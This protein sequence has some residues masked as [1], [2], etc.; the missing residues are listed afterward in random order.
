MSDK[1]QLREKL[2]IKRR[3]FQG[4]RREIAD[5]EILN[6]FLKAFSAYDSFFIYN[7]FGTE[8]D[9]HN[10]IRE[11]VKAGKKVYLPR[12][13]GDNITAV[14]YGDTET[15]AFG[16]REPVGQAFT[17]E[18]QV[19]VIPLLAVNLSGARIGY[20]KGYYDR[21]LKNAQTLKVG[22]GYGF[23]QEEF[24]GEAHDIPLDLFLC[25][26]GISFYADVRGAVEL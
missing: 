11:L 14:P 21:Y 5:A 1:C 9:T 16:I 6:C 26:K 2:K 18:I 13:E 10:I 15:G 24:E 3:Y 17:G 22:L 25:E 4:V 8:A 20:G 23:Q 12:V 7:S 19:T